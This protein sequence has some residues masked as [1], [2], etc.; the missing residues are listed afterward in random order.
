[1]KLHQTLL[2]LALT[3]PL[4]LASAG[5]RYLLA[6]V[7]PAQDD[8]SQRDTSLIRD[9]SPAPALSPEVAAAQST[10]SRLV[11]G[12]LSDS[13]YAY[14]PRAL[15]DSLSQTIF[16]DYFES[17][18]AAKLYFTAQDIQ[19]YAGL[20]T[21]LDDAIKG[22]NTDAAYEIFALYQQRAAERMAHARALLKQDIFDFSGEERW[23]YD[24]ED[25]PWAKDSAELD[26]LWKKAVLNVWLRL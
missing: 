13:R 26:T 7:A 2:C 24:R 21:T 12:L 17:L 19:K 3:A 14:R 6:Q 9:V 4:M 11:Y 15:D 5:D 20:R 18:D 25:A 10:T 16:N 8:A 22:G 23:H 1:M